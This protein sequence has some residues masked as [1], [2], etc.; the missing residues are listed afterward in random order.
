MAP[1]MRGWPVGVWVV[2]L[3][4]CAAHRPPPAVPAPLQ[5]V[6]RFAR[7]E[8]GFSV[9]GISGAPDEVRVQARF[10][11]PSG[12]EM[13]VGG[14]P[15]TGGG[16]RV[17]FT[18]QEV[19][20]Y[21]YRIQAGAKEVASGR[22]LSRPSSRRGFVRRS[23]VSAHH[24][25]WEDGTPFLPLGE[26]RFNVYDPSWN[27]G[28]QSS[29]EYIAG[30][31]A[32]GM[33]TLRVFIF[34]DCER[35]EPQP[36][37]QP[38][39]LEPRPG[40]FDAEVAARYDAIFDAAE[41]HG[42]QVVLALFAVGFTPGETWKSWEDNPYSTA[43]GG[44]AAMPDDFFDRPELAERRLRYVLARF[45]ASPS[46][47]AVDLLN[48]PEWDGN[49]GEATWMPWAV[50]LAE[51]WHAED[52]YG[53]LVTVGSVG[54]QWNVDGDE[55]PWYASRLDDLLQWH[56]YGKEFY[57][58]HAL[59]AE[60][61]RKVAETW[62]YDKPILLGEFGYGG[63]DRR[64][65]DHTHVGIWVTTFC[66][67]GVLAHSAP[68]FTEDSDVPMTPERGRHFRVLA[69]Y[70]ARLPPGPP[71]LPM[72][73]PPASP[74][75]TRSW[76]MGRPGLQ[77]LWVMGAEQGYGEPVSGAQ[78]RVG[79]GPGEYRITWWNDVT[80]EVL[81]REQRLVAQP[82]VLLSVP[83]FVRHAAGVVEAVR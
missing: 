63:E 71:L 61:T 22:F 57:E 9:P 12:R 48:E 39:C 75:G 17:R 64:T 2:L 46:L 11:A 13:D 80:G 72:E 33:N 77:A 43:R 49:V 83:P 16:F 69:D 29:A 59:A 23:P 58:V 18:P 19:G 67:A 51:T 54:L 40:V 6:E 44:P 27:Q 32:R 81:S 34:T 15:V 78:V 8:V 70:L 38:G 50:K 5:E 66:G 35:E 26:N 20:E 47:L 82:E 36:G 79:L 55:R 74:D 3:V 28:Q 45:G 10:V 4:G 56:L 73:S 60:L 62:G 53:H 31:A 7:F 68:P 41:Q 25:S 24:L 76:A 1:F 65:Y 42:L 37:P 52:P 30:M 21:R 14:F